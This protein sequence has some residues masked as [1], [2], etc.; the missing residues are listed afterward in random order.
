[1]DT[2]FHRY[3]L[4]AIL[5]SSWP[6]LEKMELI[7]VASYSYA[8]DEEEGPVINQPLPD[9]TLSQIRA[10][11]GPNPVLDIRPDTTRMFW[12][13]DPWSGVTEIETDEWTENEEDTD[14]DEDEDSDK[15]GEDNGAG[16]GS[17]SSSS[18]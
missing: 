1:M 3:I 4:S 16:R 10:A 18:Q 8:I 7:G 14:K 2:L 15:D 5:E 13:T 11:V 6:R 12:M 17:S 9:E